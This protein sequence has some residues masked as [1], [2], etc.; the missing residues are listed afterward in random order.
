ML[1][2]VQGI[3]QDGQIRLLETVPDVQQ[4]RVIVTFLDP[5]Q[6]V[7]LASRGIDAAQ[8]ADLRA[9]LRTFAV[10]WDRPEMDV[11]DAP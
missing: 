2:T 5:P 3:Y 10:D 8:A 6:V 11:Y 4:A 1:R 9:R 7:E